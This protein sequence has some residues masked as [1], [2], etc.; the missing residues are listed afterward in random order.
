[1]SLPVK[2][3]ETTLKP[4]AWILLSSTTLIDKR[5]RRKS[6]NITVDELGHALELTFKNLEIN[7]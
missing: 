3:L 1:M 6:K 2:F 7:I 4:L 5:F